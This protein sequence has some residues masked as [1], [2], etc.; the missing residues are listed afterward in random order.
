MS[1]AGSGPTEPLHPIVALVTTLAGAAAM[2][3]GGLF[4]AQH[5]GLG[6]RAQI[7]I[8]SLLLALPTF[9]ALLVA[10]GRT[11][12]Q[13]LA[14]EKPAQRMVTLSVLLGG[15]LWF[16]SIGLMELQATAWP[17]A[18]EYLEAFRAIHRALAPKNALDAMVSIFVIALA[19]AIGEEIVIRGVLLPS[20]LRPLG[21]V[22]AVGLSAFVFALVHFDAYRFAFTLAIG[23]FLGAVRVASGSLWPPILAHAT[24][25]TLTFLVA[26]LVDDPSQAYTP[27]PLLGLV[28]LVAGAAV[29]VP[30]GRALRRES[31]I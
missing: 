7:A 9:A 2:V 18:P 19:P 8:G 22:G 4:M 25:N 1:T 10:R 27:Q 23:L 31:P 17:P 16:L 13:T 3:G 20:L 6:L 26:P 14:L 11:L 30:L 28:C 24:L 12:K 15:A 21:R 5:S 29:T